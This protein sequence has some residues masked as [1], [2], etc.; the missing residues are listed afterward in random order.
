MEDSITEVYPP[1]AAWVEQWEQ[2]RGAVQEVAPRGVG[3]E[4]PQEACPL[5]RRNV[6]W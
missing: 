3:E 4:A 2:L 5:Q 1:S 6:H